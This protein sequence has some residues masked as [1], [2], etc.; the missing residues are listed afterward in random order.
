MMGVNAR[1]AFSS[2][3]AQARTRFLEAAAGAGLRVE[4][5][6][7]PERGR[8]G[9]ELAM[10]IARDGQADTSNLLVLTSACHGAE[11]YCGSG[12]QVAALAD[13]QWREHARSKGV[14][15]LYVHAL[16]PYG[17]SHISRVTHENIDL[18]RNFHDFSKPLPGN[19]AYRDIHSLLLPA[20]WPPSAENEAALQAYIDK[21]GVAAYQAAISQGQHEFPDGMF[22]GGKQP[23]WSN[24]ALRDV[25]RANGKRASRI[26]WID[27]HTGLGPSGHGERI[28]AGP[29]DPASVARARRWW[30][31]GDRTPVTSIYDGTS[32]SAFLT[33]LMWN[34]AREECPR[35]EFT[36][37]ALE[38]G[39]V[40]LLVTMQRLRA[41]HWLRL[42]PQ[43]P[44]ELRKAIKQDVLDAFYTDTDQWRE[45][46][47]TQAREAMFQAVDGLASA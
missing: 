20:R 10:D 14:A 8:D 9:E 21:V 36:S 5:R 16:N 42:N 28:F 2:S 4:S 31:G 3:Y 15:V 38:Y 40:P 39:T 29:D 46:V 18:N 24:S 37:I 7:H 45:Q 12:V 23:S 30:S 13:A 22:F 47:L 27:I 6:V 33:G 19:K 44:D 26:G 35:A 1:G 41:D 17:F 43:A 34:A 32:S 25:L 11:G